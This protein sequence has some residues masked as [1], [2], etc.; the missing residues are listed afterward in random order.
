MASLTI[1][2]VPE[3]LYRRLKETAQRSRRSLNSE[4]IHR[5]ERSLGVAPV[6]T[7]ALLARTRAVRE[8]GDLPYLTDRELREKR[9]EG[10]A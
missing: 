7:D 5:L 6:D 2:N 9:D 8:R 10:R 4:I 1:K 3:P